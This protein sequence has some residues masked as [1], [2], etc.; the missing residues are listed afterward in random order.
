MS[1]QSTQFSARGQGI[2]RERVLDVLSQ[3]DWNVAK[4]A[5]ILGVARNTLYQKIKAHNLR[6]P[7]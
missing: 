4:T 1:Q 5:R 2:E 3:T 6:R 7:M